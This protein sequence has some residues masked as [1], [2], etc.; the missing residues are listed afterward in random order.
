MN[1]P[2][3]PSD[4]ET[5]PD[6]EDELPEVD[7]DVAPELTAE[8]ELAE[9]N[10]RYLRLA[11]EFDNYRKRTAREWQ[12][13]VRA[14]NSELLYDLLD[15]VDNFERALAVDHEESAYADGVRMILQQLQAQLEKRGVKEIPALGETFDPALHEALLYVASP[16]YDEGHVCQEIRRGYMLH[17]RVLR[18]AQVAVSKGAEET[19]KENNASQNDEA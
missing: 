16:E 15:I 5:P 1:E 6:S 9:Q 7:A 11:A 4:V 3:D 10:E 12:D 18:V 8:E 13:R 14:A 17:E 19:G 2:K